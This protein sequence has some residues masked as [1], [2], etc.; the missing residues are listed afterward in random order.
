MRS[1]TAK[2]WSKIVHADCGNS[3]R[4]ALF[5]AWSLSDNNEVEMM[6]NADFDKA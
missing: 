1:R 2:C 4:K 6:S 5:F 3:L